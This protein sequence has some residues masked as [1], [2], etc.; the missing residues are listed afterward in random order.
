[1]PQKRYLV[2]DSDDEG[3]LEGDGSVATYSSTSSI[4][5]KRRCSEDNRSIVI[6]EG[7]SGWKLHC[8]GG[9]NRLQYHSNTV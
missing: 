6:S 3:G 8:F 4:A 5:S 1:M 9:L 2:E 7:E